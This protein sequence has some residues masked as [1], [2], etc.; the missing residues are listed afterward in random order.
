LICP[1]RGLHNL[2]VL[3]DPLLYLR[4]SFLYEFLK[5]RYINIK[6]RSIFK[7][8]KI[9]IQMKPQWFKNAIVYQILID[10]FSGA[11]TSVNKPDFLG[12]N[13]KGITERLDYILEL[14]V[15]TIWLSPFYRTNKYHGYHIIDFKNMDNHFG[16]I[17]DLKILI[18]KAHENSF[19]IITDIVPNH[20]SV[21]HPFFIEAKHNRNS[22]YYNWFYFKKWPDDYLC[23]LNVKELA[24][25]NPDNRETQDYIID[26]TKYWLSSGIDGYRI[27]HVIGPSHKFWKRFHNEIKA[28]Y[29]DCV[30]FGE[31]WGE[32]ISLA[33]FETINIRNKFFHKIF[34]IS[35]EGLQKE[36]YGEMDGILDFRLNEII[37]KAVSKGKGFTSDNEFRNKVR[38]HFSKYPEDYYLVTF[39][40]NHD[41]NRF[42]FYCNGN[43]DLLLEALE[44][45]LTTGKPVVIYYGTEIGMCNTIPVSVDLHHSDLNVREPVDWC[46]INDKLYNRVKG[47][48]NK[49][50]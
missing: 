8:D 45:L 21:K 42:L 40:D 44:F 36:Y 35:Q 32:G 29:P 3:P 38:N 48:I 22:K 24:K 13:I 10:R 28:G 20:C 18:E 47:L 6:L 1:P 33:C 4:Y 7:S 34:G 9:S 31:A 12:G 5:L 17:D 49:L 26:V 37:I 16:S 23:F 50:H 19:R 15:N 11:D 27:D 30:L 46:K 14:G 25:L 41:M 39:L 2:L 43:F